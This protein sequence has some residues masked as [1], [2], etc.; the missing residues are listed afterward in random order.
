MSL[1]AREISGHVGGGGDPEEE[2]AKQPGLDRGPRGER[3]EGL[4]PGL[5]GRLT[6]LWPGTR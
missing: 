2:G 6:Q 1:G 5:A 3:G 4:V